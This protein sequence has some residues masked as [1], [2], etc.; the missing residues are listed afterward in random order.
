MGMGRSSE[1][2]HIG[3]RVVKVF[4]FGEKLVCKNNVLNTKLG[5]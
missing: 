1:G 4:I 2:L 3:E 5:T